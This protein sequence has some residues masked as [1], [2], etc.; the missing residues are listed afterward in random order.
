MIEQTLEVWVETFTICL[1]EVFHL[2]ASSV[3]PLSLEHLMAT[4]TFLSRDNS[5]CNKLPIILFL[6]LSN[7]K[8]HASSYAA[9]LD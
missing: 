3:T 2:E 4:Q 6:N 1:S 9:F 5:Y 8:G 7:L